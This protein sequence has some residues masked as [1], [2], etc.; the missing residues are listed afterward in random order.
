[1]KLVS[2]LF[3][4]RA[5]KRGTATTKTSPIRYCGKGSTVVGKVLGIPLL[6]ITYC[7]N[8]GVSGVVT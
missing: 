4:S 3:E 5:S 2:H 8:S 1:M 7:D 6:V